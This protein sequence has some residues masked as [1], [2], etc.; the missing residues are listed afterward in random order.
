MA[1]QSAF[2][3]SKGKP[4]LLFSALLFFLSF[5]RVQANDSLALAQ[6]Y[7]NL[8]LTIEYF[9]SLNSDRISRIIPYLQGELKGIT[10]E[11]FRAQN[12]A[13]RML[14]QAQLVFLKTKF[15]YETRKGISRPQLLA[16]KAGLDSAD[17]YLQTMRS[18]SNVREW[19]YN[20]YY[21]LIGVTSENLERLTSGIWRMKYELNKHFNLDIYPDVQRLY[22]KAKESGQ[23]H[24]DSLQY[25]VGL[26]G[27]SLDFSILANSDF[28]NRELEQIITANRWS[29]YRVDL[30]IELISRYLQLDYVAKKAHDV[31]S[32]KDLHEALGD[33]EWKL[34]LGDSLQFLDNSSNYRNDIAKDNFFITELGE[35]T[36]ASLREHLLNKFPLDPDEHPEKLLS[37]ERAMLEAGNGHDERFYFPK[38]APFPSAKISIQNFLKDSVRLEQV[39]H[40][41]RKNFEAA[42]YLGRLHYFYLH[43]PGFA[44][45][46]GIER[47][48]KDGAPKSPE[49]SRWDLTAG[50]D[51]SFSLYKIFKAIF[52]ATESDFR[53]IACVVSTKEAVTGNT[54]GSF[55]VF[56]RLLERSYSSLP[57]DLAKVEMPQKTLTILVYH[58]YQ[59]DIGQ[60][61]VLDTSKRLTVYQHLEKTRS[62]KKITEN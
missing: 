12:G 32:K 60:V 43:E 11:S 56:S 15:S 34:N 59:S 28:P 46:T 19:A 42:G 30:A 33:F 8:S 17:S 29:Y 37:R 55:E 35:T 58:F 2:G 22:F 21:E 5:Y 13:L 40:Y 50:A 47:I 20:E 23:Y 49:S 7:I 44:V 51:G 38:V 36:I 39:D 10:D 53:I 48:Q 62:L 9:D 61:P 27:M 45:T 41:I 18:V 4:K 57:T 24:F 1:T 25:F 26:Y 52:F 14:T 16:W 3:S 31:R 54:P 6:S